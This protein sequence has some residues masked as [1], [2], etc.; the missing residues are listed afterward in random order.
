MGAKNLFIILGLGILLTLYFITLTNRIPNIVMRVDTILSK[1]QRFFSKIIVTKGNN[2][3]IVKDENDLLLKAK[4]ISRYNRTVLLTLVNDAYLKFTY[5]WLCNTKNMGI[6]KSVLI[7]TT[8]Q[9]SKDNL[10]RDWPDISVVLVDIKMQG[11][12]EYS[13]AGYVKIMVKRTEMIMSIILA[14]I[15]VFLFEVDCLWLDN[16][17]PNLQKT[18]G[19]D[20]LVNPVS[21]TENQTFAGGF[22]W[23]YATDKTKALWKKL[24]EEMIALGKNIR[25]KPDKAQVSRKI[26]DQTIFSRLV[27]QKLVLIIL[28]KDYH[29]ILYFSSGNKHE[30]PKRD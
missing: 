21:G 14:N 23:L 29:F 12:Q 13:K 16:P 28:S 15:S 5:S 17:V 18:T 25:Y 27:T 2:N 6:H 1:T 3:V 30:R 22:V 26:N 24:T 9:T 19:Y 11:D 4:D 7:V 10:T 20:I 8:D